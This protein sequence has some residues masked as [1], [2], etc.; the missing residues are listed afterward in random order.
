M[1]AW[2]GELR[3]RLPKP[4]LRLPATVW[5][6]ESWPPMPRLRTRTLR[7]VAAQW[8]RVAI[9]RRR[10]PGNSSSPDAASS[11]GDALTATRP[12]STLRRNE[13][14]AGANKIPDSGESSAWRVRQAS[15]DEVKAEVDSRSRP[16]NRLR[17]RPPP[18]RYS[19]PAPALA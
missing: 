7:R 10:F 13:P 17:P 5:V 8:E 19:Q 9:V 6:L 1:R 18:R 16:A 15:V 11:A 2:Q 14:G 3:M 12:E 4:P